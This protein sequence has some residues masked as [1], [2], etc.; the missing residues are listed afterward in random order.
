MTAAPLRF[1]LFGTGF[2][3]RFQLG[4]W[5]E[6]AGARCVALYN[7]TRAK[8]EVLG[9]EVGIAAVYDDAEELLRHEELDFVDVVSSPDTHARFV[10]LAAAHRKPVIC[11]KPMA[12]DLQTAARMVTRCRE[13]RV[14]FLVH[15]NWRWQTPI[16]AVKAALD[17]GAIGAVFRARLTMVSGFELF[18]NQ[19]F[20]AELEQFVLT[21]MGSHV[22]DVARFL[23]GEAESLCCHTGRVHRHIKGEDVA[24]VMLRMR[25]GAAVIVELGYPG[26]PYGERERFPE[27]FV[28]VEGERGVVELGA[29]YWVRLT[30]GE[31]TL[32]RRHA[33]PRYAWAD[34]RYDVVHASGVPCNQN[35]LAALRGEFEAETTGEDNLRTLRLVFAAYESAASGRSVCVDGQSQGVDR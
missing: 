7:R 5:R 32:S 17:S 28:Y 1:A 8:A 30:T 10:E 25:S 20:L 21:D 9:R 26:T 3:A 23:F 24:T 19:P 35:L 27:T 15:E 16:R 22:L 11:Q 29:D 12:S 4:A 14:P 34:P 6:V 33:P 2:W 31:G 13:A 18:A